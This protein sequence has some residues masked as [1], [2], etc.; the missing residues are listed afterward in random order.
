MKSIQARVRQ[1]RA[2]HQTLI[3]EGKIPADADVLD[4][5][6]SVGLKTIAELESEHSA[7]EAGGHP[8]GD[9]GDFLDAYLAPLQPGK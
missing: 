6:V 1:I 7:K 9:F 5:A 8:V 4:Y 2:D 3:E